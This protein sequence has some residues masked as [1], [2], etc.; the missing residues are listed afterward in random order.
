[1]IAAFVRPLA[2]AAALAVFVADAQA[3]TRIERVVSPGGIE[4]W[5]V[6]DQSVPLVSMNF[7]FRGGATQD[8][9]EKP[10]VAYMTAGLLDEGAGNL[11]A[12]AFSE[13]VEQNA[14]ELRFS[15]QRDEVSGALRVLRDR[16]DVG[17]DL[18][19][20]ALTAPRFD[21]EPIERVRAQMLTALRRETTNPNN[22]A[23]RLWWRTAFPD[24]PYGRPANGTLESVPLI[25]RDDVAAYA[26]RV[27]ARDQLKIAVVGD[28]DAATL[29]PLLDTVFGALPAK[30][31]LVAVKPAAAV[32]GGRR[33][34]VDLKVPQAVLSFGGNG[35]A[36][37]DPDFIPAFIVNHILGGGSFSSRLYREVR[38]KRGLVYSV[39]S[40]LLPLD[41]TALVLGGTQ[42]RADRADE[43]LDLIE[44]EIRRMSE[45]GPMA[46]ELAKAKSYLKG[47]YALNFDTSAK[48]AAQLVQIQLEDLGIDYIE[49]RN[50]LIEK[51]TLDD[52]RRAAK[53]LLNTGVLYSV[54]GRASET[55]AGK[56]GG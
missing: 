3:A 54:V 29:A 27:F 19:R 4:A 49:R 33:L 8:P 18:L 6:Q 31:D 38:E 32:G 40:Y 56:Q 37:K 15:A 20:L 43:T 12:R 2:A 42:T 48:I 21:A 17:F 39:Y 50:G 51:V 10:G 22:I 14:V 30:A 16:M 13:K 53:R 1:M 23:S 7:A 5:L 28:I 46:D 52:V 35:I 44:S 41:R 34:Y 11:D 24:H 47:S 36:R 26:R 45:S 55:P 25:G 9:P